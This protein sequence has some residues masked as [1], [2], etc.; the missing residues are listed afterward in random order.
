MV[1]GLE[2]AVIS[3]VSRRALPLGGQASFITILL[4][5]GILS[6]LPSS[7]GVNQGPGALLGMINLVFHITLGS[8][9]YSISAEMPATRLRAHFIA[10]GRMFYLLPRAVDNQLVPRINAPDCWNWGA[11]C[12]SFFAGVNP[13]RARRRPS[14]A[15]PRPESGATPSSRSCSPTV[16]ARKFASTKV[17]DE[18]AEIVGKMD[19]SDDASPSEGSKG[20]VVVYIRTVGKSGL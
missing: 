18:T 10:L 17:W 20:D 14:S 11:K 16:P 19:S 6:S 3:R 13:L 1:C 5:I 4:L 7:N 15:S 9:V 12:G 8:I 2:L